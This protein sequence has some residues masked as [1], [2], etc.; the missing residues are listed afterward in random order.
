MKRRKSVRSKRTQ[1][2]K[3]RTHNRKQIRK[4]TRSKKRQNV[5]RMKRSQ[6][7]THKGGNN[8]EQKLKSCEIRNT[9]LKNLI[10]KLTQDYLNKQKDLYEIAGD[11][12][13]IFTNVDRNRRPSWEGIVDDWNS[14]VPRKKKKK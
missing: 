4:N 1:K 6:K 13:S 12:R 7:S 10:N 9:K 5:R 2:R 8:C 14:R 3:L 11:M